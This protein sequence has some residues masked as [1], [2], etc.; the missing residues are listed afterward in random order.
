KE[1]ARPRHMYKGSLGRILGPLHPARAGE[2]R[3]SPHRELTRVPRY[4]VGR[5]AN[6]GVDGGEGL[7]DIAAVRRAVARLAVVRVHG[8]VDALEILA[9]ELGH[10][11][12]GLHA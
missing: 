2:R 1:L 12:V 8:K 10:G 3:L 9:E 6:V 11:E 5:D 4:A 7:A